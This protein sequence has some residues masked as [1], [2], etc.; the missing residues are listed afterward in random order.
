MLGPINMYL[1]MIYLIKSI[2]FFILFFAIFIGKGV[3]AQEPT[4]GD[5]SSNWARNGE[6]D[7]PRFEGSGMA[8]YLIDS[9]RL[10]DATDCE[11]LFNLGRVSLIDVNEINFGDD[12]SNWARNG[13]CDDPRF[14]GSGMASY[15]IDSDRL[16]DAT[17]CEALFNLGEVSLVGANEI[18]FGDDS[19]D[20]ANDGECDD[21]RFEGPGMASYLTDSDRL[22]DATDCEALFNLGEVTL[23][24]ANEIIFGDDSSNWANDG[25]CDDP[26]FEGPGMASYLI[27]SDRL[28]DATDCQ[29]L[30]IQGNISLKATDGINFGDDSSNWA[31]NG[32]C[33][34]PRFEGSGMASYLIDSDRLSDATDCRLL[35]EQG[36]VA[37]VS[38]WTPSDGDYPSSNDI[39]SNERELI[40]ASSGT[41]FFVSG[42]GH[43]LTNHHVIDGCQNVEAHIDG[44][45]HKVTV[46]AVDT[47]NDLALIK[48]ELSPAAVFPV[49]REAPYLLQDIYV[50]GY[51]FGDQVSSSVKVTSGI[52]SS[53]T[54]IGDNVSNIQIDA[55][56]Q[57]GNSGGPI[58][59]QHGNAIG[60]AVAKLDHTA[61]SNLFDAVP[62]NVN[63]GIRSSVAANLLDLNDVASPDADITIL[64]QQNLGQRISEGTLYLSCWMSPSQIDGVRF[65]RS[66][67][68]GL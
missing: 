48:S 24:V 65:L 20:W 25:E 19:S 14:Q 26:R 62:E 63:F 56:L 45:Q 50:A 44:E 57:P 34:D 28:S 36:D 47:I 33:D 49:S 1:I 11:A 3:L 66:L 2:K 51:P 61:I 58:I 7:D 38:G 42:Q 59:D 43:I 15:L 4:F 31:R 40:E 10:S 9:D 67:F 64:S 18:I 60:V 30:F 35:F 23:V 27:D 46:I 54:G 29:T 22:S 32:E 21:S 37:L 5:D 53:L 17:D 6:C 39:G 8:S 55:A 52:V 41:G 16:S 68:E 13:E 12:S